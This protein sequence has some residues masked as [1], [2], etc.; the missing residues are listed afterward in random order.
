MYVYIMFCKK[1]S[2]SLQLGM[3][4]LLQIVIQWIDMVMGERLIL[5]KGKIEVI[6][7]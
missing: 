7:S 3:L 5:Q 4:Q 1:V 2:F 6:F